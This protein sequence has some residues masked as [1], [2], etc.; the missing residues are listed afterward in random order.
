MLNWMAHL[1]QRSGVKL[2]VCPVLQGGQGSGKGLIIQILGDILGHEHFV[3][4][5]FVSDV[6]GTFQEDRMKTN[7]LIFST[8][9]HGAVITRLLAF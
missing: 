4:S 9:L 5:T 8:N 7:L 6:T 2:C 1:V 3:A